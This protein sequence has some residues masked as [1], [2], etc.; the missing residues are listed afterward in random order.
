M[1]FPPERVFVAALAI[2]AMVLIAPP[3]AADPRPL[4]QDLSLAMGFT[5]DR[6]VHECPGKITGTYTGEAALL[7]HLVERDR[8]TGEWIPVMDVRVRTGPG[9]QW[10]WTNAIRLEG[11]ARRK[12]DQTFEMSITGGLRTLQ[13]RVVVIPTSE[14]LAE[15]SFLFKSCAV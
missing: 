6:T 7:V 14:Q 15:E 5:V 8:A 10:Q 9:A 13:L 11:A 1:T 12:A 2:L 3:A 4:T